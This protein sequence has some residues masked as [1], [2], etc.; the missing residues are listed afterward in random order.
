MLQ[1]A[2][3][4]YG[5]HVTAMVNGETQIE[6]CLHVIRHPFQEAGFTSIACGSA[7][8]WDKGRC[9][10]NRQGVKCLCGTSGAALSIAKVSSVNVG[11]GAL[12]CQS[13]RF[14]VLMWDKWRC[15]VN[16]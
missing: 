10:F 7:C 15:V 8:M 4:G 1:I 14:Q 5:S 16:R 9:I 2:N 12:R 11:Q 6:R 3:A 13:S